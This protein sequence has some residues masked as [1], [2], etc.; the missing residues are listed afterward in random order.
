M[1]RFKL[2]P[3]RRPGRI[4]PNSCGFIHSHIVSA[5]TSVLRPAQGPPCERK[6]EHLKVDSLLFAGLLC[7]WLRQKH[8]GIWMNMPHVSSLP[9]TNPHRKNTNFQFFN[10]LKLYPQDSA[11]QGLGTRYLPMVSDLIFWRVLVLVFLFDFNPAGV[12]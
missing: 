2:S 4:K 6:P 1:V 5:E 3:P 7:S 10:A 11:L 12:V 9:R 8:F